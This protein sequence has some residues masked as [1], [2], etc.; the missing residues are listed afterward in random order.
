MNWPQGA[1]R[2]IDVGDGLRLHVTRAG[3]GLPLVLLH[4][5]TGS[6]ETWD[7]L[8]RALASDAGAI[9]VDLTGHGR[10]GTPEDPARYALPRLADDLACVLDALSLH[11]AVVLGYSLGGRA[12][13][14]LALRHPE[15]V[16]ALVLESASP[17]LVDP[18]ERAARRAAD[19]ALADAIERDGV[20]AFVERWERLPLW[21][22]QATLPAETR[23]GLRAQRLR[24]HPRG[25]ANSLRGAGAGVEPPVHE[26]LGALD[27]PT[28]LIAG[29]LD[30]KYVAIAESLERIMPRARGVVVPGAGHAV[31]LERPAAFAAA[32]RAF[33]TAV[34]SLDAAP[35]VPLR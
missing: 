17:G 33:L 34:P 21:A 10:S 19:A 6:S 12:A 16:A 29:A 5:F 25:L 22:S 35:G 26:R 15:R 30:A 13:L 11:R 27:V 28:L 32:V 4:G 23:A 31:H 9:A 1:G 7:S 20:A 8:Q 24:N 14:H 18:A 2:E 3:D